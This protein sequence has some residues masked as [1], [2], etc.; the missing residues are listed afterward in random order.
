M[1]VDPEVREVLG[2]IVEL[3]YVE[4]RDGQVINAINPIDNLCFSRWDRWSPTLKYLRD[5]ARYH[6]D[7]GGEFFV[8]LY[9]GW[10]EYSEPALGSERKY[11]P[12]RQL[13][14]TG[15]HLNYLGTG[16]AGE[17]RF[18]HPTGDGESIDFSVYPELPRK[19]LTYN[20]HIGDNN[21]LL[22]PDAE[23][24]ENGFGGFLADV[25]RADIPWADK[26]FKF[27]WRGSQNQ[28]QG[29]SYYDEGYGPVHP[30]ALAVQYSQN[31]YRD[32]V[33]DAAYATGGSP[34]WML[35]NKFVMDIDGMV[36]AWSG[37]YWKLYSNSAVVK[38]RTHWE[39][40]YYDKLIPFKHYIPLNSFGNFYRTVDWCAHNDAKCQEIAAAGKDL[41][42]G[43]TYEYAI[44]AYI[45]R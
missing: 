33:I 32:P 8:C 7:F 45:I 4:I 9:D 6:E 23:F 29:L 18:R 30:R 2:D 14:S 12:W 16:R 25:D 26:D 40:W 19:V 37:L 17:R 31:M 11:V 1:E 44:K 10:R 35:K 24:L 21:A 38:F 34:G 28:D 5:Y 13:K 15:L 42:A 3:G 20:R 43:L 27:V 41:V 22:I 36:N 39:Q